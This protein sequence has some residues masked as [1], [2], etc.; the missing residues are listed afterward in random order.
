MERAFNRTLLLFVIGKRILLVVLCVG[1]F[2]LKI[3][4]EAEGKVVSVLLAIIIII[5]QTI[6][7]GSM[8]GHESEQEGGCEVSL[9]S[10]E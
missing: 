8:L 4:Y 5:S 9:S 2:V 6:V 3:N 10:N 7:E 1:G